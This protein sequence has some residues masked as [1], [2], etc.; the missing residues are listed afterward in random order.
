ME[1]FFSPCEV[2]VRVGPPNLFPPPFCSFIFVI[3]RVSFPFEIEYLIPPV[4]FFPPRLKREGIVL[5][6]HLRDRFSP[7]FFQIV[8]EPW[9]QSIVLYFFQS[10]LFPRRS[11]SKCPSQKLRAALVLGPLFSLFRLQGPLRSA[12][13]FV[14]SWIAFFTTRSRCPTPPFSSN[15]SSVCVSNAHFMFLKRD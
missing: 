8:I 5:T 4:S 15:V 11:P 6:K 12:S 13:L 9:S 2:L 10:S 3:I 7:Y 14:S 1:R